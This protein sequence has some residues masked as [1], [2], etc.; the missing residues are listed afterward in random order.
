MSEAPSRLTL[1]KVQH[2]HPAL[3]QLELL[4]EG[5]VRI[6]LPRTLQPLTRALPVLMLR[7]R[8]IVAGHAAVAEETQTQVVSISR[9]SRADYAIRSGCRQQQLIEE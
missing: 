3:R 5:L 7:R 8:P 2:D 9:P 4:S 1:L 6:E